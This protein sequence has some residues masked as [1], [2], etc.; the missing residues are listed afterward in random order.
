MNRYFCV[1]YLMFYALVCHAENRDSL[2]NLLNKA[3]TPKETYLIY[4]KAAVSISYISMQ[5]SLGYARLA[6]EAVKNTNDLETKA[7]A[8]D[9][10][11]QNYLDVSNYDSAFYFLNQCVIIA[12][13]CKDY[14]EIGKAYIN[15]TG[16]YLEIKNYAR[17]EEYNT[18]ASAIFKSAHDN[19]GILKCIIGLGEIKMSQKQYAASLKN[20]L[21]ALKLN[22]DSSVDITKLLYDNIGVAY[23]DMG[24]NVKALQYIDNLYRL[25]IKTVDSV[26]IAIAL[27]TKGGIYTKLK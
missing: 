27:E 25:S 16:G 18:K 2:A 23:E 22:H 26:N 14:N 17:A 9:F 11:G 19:K 4:R 1:L 3:K 15:L 24:D 21:E 6:F 13:K 8:L 10:L 20:F 7:A 12:E 5:K